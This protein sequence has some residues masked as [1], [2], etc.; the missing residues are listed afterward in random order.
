MNAP[1]F[2]HHFS[3]LNQFILDLV[4]AYEAGKINS[5]EDLEPL[6]NA[7][8]TPER[9]RH[10]ESV[11][12]HWQKMAS[13]QGGVTLV[14]V[15]CV[16]LGMY[17]LPGYKSLSEDQQ[18]LM[19]WIILFHDIE[20][21]IENGKRDPTH[22]FR[23]AAIGAKR[24]PSFGFQVTEEY[25]K[26]IDSWSAF[27][28]CATTAS[29]RTSELIQDNRR[30]PEILSGIDSLFGKNTP[31]ALIVKT[32]LF[33]SS[34]NVVKAWP[35]LSPLTDEEIR[36]YIDRDLLPL[37]EVMAL[38]DNEGWTMFYAEDRIT[39]RIETLATFEQ[40]QSEID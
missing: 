19:K 25:S 6:V 3:S 39:Q 36:R 31:P 8:F 1:N 29:E 4:A 33:H 34:I 11:L 5:W 28:S 26:L 13:Y 22:S 15:M 35:Q 24:L 30:V 9:M 38:S 16:F 37:L 20:K 32:V 27:V 21:E 2:D 12:P 18:N 14:H 7:Y 10:M 40:I 17:M 23:S